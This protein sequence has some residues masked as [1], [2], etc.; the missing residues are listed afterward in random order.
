MPEN[1][2]EIFL[3]FFKNAK[4]PLFQGLFYVLRVKLCYNQENLAAFTQAFT[5]HSFGMATEQ[6]PQFISTSVFLN[7]II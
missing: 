5:N 2:F 3:I 4:I 6:Q 1:I 7:L